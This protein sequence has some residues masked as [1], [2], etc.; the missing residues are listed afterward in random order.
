MKGKLIIADAAMVHP[1]NKL[2]MLGAFINVINVPRGQ[3]IFFTGSL[4]ACIE[5]SAAE[6]GQHALR[7][8]C[9]DDDGHPA[10]PPLEVRFEAPAKDGR[11]IVVAGMN[12]VFP[13]EESYEWHLTVDGHELDTYRLEAGHNPLQQTEGK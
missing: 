9:L 7:V 2:C 13:R 12:V 4:V 6:H 3:P 8:V 10:F 11:H 5:H 1:D